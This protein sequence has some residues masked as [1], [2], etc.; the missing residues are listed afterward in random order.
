MHIAPDSPAHTQRVFALQML[1]LGLSVLLGLVVII[2]YSSPSRRMNAEG[3][4]SAAPMYGVQRYPRPVSDFMGS[5]SS[6]K[7]LQRSN[8]SEPAEAASEAAA[9]SA[10]RIRRTTSSARATEERVLR[11]T[12]RSRFQDR[13]PVQSPSRESGGRFSPGWFWR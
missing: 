3:I 2:Q 6:A 7:R 9:S 5:R 10:P 12:E 13:R 8:G 1:F 4:Y 11:R